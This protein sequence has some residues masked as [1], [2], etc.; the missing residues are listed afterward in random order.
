[1]AANPRIPAAE[2]AAA[3]ADFYTLETYAAEDSVGYLIAVLRT[4]QFRALDVEFSKFG[5]TAAQWPI[6]RMVAD[7][8]TPTAADLCRHLSYDTGSMT[9]MLNRL[10]QKG[11]IVRVPSAA[12]RRVVQLK[13]T[14]AGRRMHRKLRQAAIRVL[15]H[16]VRG[17][18]P[19]E[20]HQLH[21]QLVRMHANLEAAY[22][23]EQS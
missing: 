12:D 10:E 1:M 14:P 13:I 23:N 11:V 19:L 21:E 16:L 4:R 15:N 5:F 20:I 17:F 3:S 18:S 6:L 8:E 9:R 22:P 7:G 2:P